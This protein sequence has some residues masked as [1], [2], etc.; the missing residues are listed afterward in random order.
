MR[1]LINEV[2]GTN[3][4]KST[5]NQP[6]QREGELRIRVV[7]AVLTRDTDIFTYSFS[8]MINSILVKW[9]HM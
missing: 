5:G 3:I 8:F 2:T 4:F 9:I 6:Y 1:K 7:S